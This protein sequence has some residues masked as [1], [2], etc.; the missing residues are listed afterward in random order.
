M[1]QPAQMDNQEWNKAISFLN[2]GHILQSWEWGE[3]KDKYSWK[4]RRF[5]WKDK[6]ETKILA[7]AQILERTVTVFRINL[8]MKIL[9]IPRGPLL[10]DW[11]NRSL[12][13]TVIADLKNYAA[14][15]HAIFIKIDPEVIIE[16]E[17]IQLFRVNS[18]IN[19]EEIRR[20]LRTEGWQYS[21]EQIQFKNT[22]WINLLPD[23]GEILESMKQKT[24]YN[25]H[26]SE[27][28]GVKIHI[29]TQDELP[30]LYDLYMKTSNRDGFIIRPIE[31]YLSLWQVLISKNMASGLIAEVDGVPVAGLILFHFARKAWYFYGM[32]S[33]LNREKMPNYQLQW[34]AIR[35]AKKLG[36]EIYDLWGAPDKLD[37]ND[38]MSG[39]YRFKLGLGGKLIKTIGAWDYPV[40]KIIYSI[41]N[42]VLPKILSFFR[43]FRS[44]QIRREIVN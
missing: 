31:Y 8:E 25:L 10:I 43:F 22:A 20:R 30:T 37:G 1:M 5:I 4:V 36:C 9:Y 19:G 2:G 26:L 12:F 40:N 15:Q 39:V 42:Y 41:Y 24:R 29:A 23:E 16:A 35:L 33:E 17:D 7:A 11:N 21:P 38:P 6:Q 28:K 44:R 3:F 18:Q 13:R 27:R 32:S 14:K 34:E